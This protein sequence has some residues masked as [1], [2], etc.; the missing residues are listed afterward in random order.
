M[1]P[2]EQIALIKIQRNW[3]GTCFEAKR[4]QQ[5]TQQIISL[6]KTA[7]TGQVVIFW[8]RNLPIMI[9]I[10]KINPCFCLLAT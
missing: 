9:N 7:F 5:K 4:N 10:D 6:C 2:L 8:C 1:T 3:R